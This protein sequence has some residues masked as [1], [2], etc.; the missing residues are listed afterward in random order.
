MMHEVQSIEKSMS[1]DIIYVFLGIINEYL[2]RGKIINVG[3][4]PS[5]KIIA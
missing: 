4:V 5:M 2:R 3:R 1:M